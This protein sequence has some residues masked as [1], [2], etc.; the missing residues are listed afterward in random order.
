[1]IFCVS[2]HASDIIRK[3]DSAKNGADLNNKNKERKKINSASK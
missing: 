2:A 3:D 1:M